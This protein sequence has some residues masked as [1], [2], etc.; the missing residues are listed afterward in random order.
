M[1]DCL[2]PVKG[3]IRRVIQKSEFVAVRNS[4]RSDL[5]VAKTWTSLAGEECNIVFQGS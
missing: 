2:K 5:G 3:V 1:I 4:T